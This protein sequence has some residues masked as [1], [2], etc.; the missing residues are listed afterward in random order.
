MEFEY[1]AYFMAF[2][3]CYNA[4]ASVKTVA[5]AEYTATIRDGIG[6]KLRRDLN[7]Y[8][9][10]FSTHQDK[11]ATDFANTANDTYLKTS[12][13]ASGVGS[14]SEVCDLL[15]NWHIQEVVL[16]SITVEENR[17]DPYDESQVDVSDIR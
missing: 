5:A 14:Y 12:G 2:R 11:A 15:V 13:E 6:D 10:F 3:Y 1:S 8:S 7:D 16:P 17:F 9:D 4:L